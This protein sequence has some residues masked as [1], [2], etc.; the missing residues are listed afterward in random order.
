MAENATGITNAF[1]GSAPAAREPEEDYSWLDKAF[2]AAG[3]LPDDTGEFEHAAQPARPAPAP[4]PTPA[5]LAAVAAQKNREQLLRELFTDPDRFIEERLT[6]KTASPNQEMEALKALVLRTNRALHQERVDRAKEVAMSRLKDATKNNQAIQSEAVRKSIAEAMVNLVDQAY[7]G[8]PEAF[9]TLQNPKLAKLIIEAA[10]IDTEFS[11][12][13]QPKPTPVS[14]AGGRPE[15]GSTVGAA[16]GTPAQ[17]D[18][19]TAYYAERWGIKPE[20]A[21]ENARLATPKR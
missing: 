4:A 16:P 5:D 13:T 17:L 21:A 11:G 19:V 15:G 12:L 1:T 2:E 8:N 18:E 20:T 10:K 7:Q 14:Y 6:R 3:S 9:K